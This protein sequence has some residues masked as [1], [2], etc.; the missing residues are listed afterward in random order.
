LL[1]HHTPEG[2]ILTRKLMVS[3]LDVHQTLML[4]KQGIGDRQLM[5]L[6]IFIPHKGIDAVNKKQE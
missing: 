3:D 1:R 4:Q 2:P 5:G 6:G